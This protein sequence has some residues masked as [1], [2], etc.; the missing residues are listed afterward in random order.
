MSGPISRSNGF[1]KKYLRR[2][3]DSSIPLGGFCAQNS[4]NS[5]LVRPK[6][7]LLLSSSFSTRKA[8]KIKKKLH[9]VQRRPGKVSFAFIVGTPSSSD[10]FRDL[11]CEGRESLLRVAERRID[12]WPQSMQSS[13]K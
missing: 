6:T 7:H 9:P 13:S 3:K 8:V 11:S 12:K 10:G 1:H 2:D 4:I 5:E